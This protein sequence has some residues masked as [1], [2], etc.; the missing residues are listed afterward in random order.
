MAFLQQFTAALR[1]SAAPHCCTPHGGGG[2]GGKRV[3]TAA[4]AAQ[5]PQIVGVFGVVNEVM[6]G[7]L[8]MMNNENP[9]VLIFGPFAVILLLCRPCRGW[10]LP[11]FWV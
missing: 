1:L 8:V 5:I 3:V 2:G 10:G 11:F 6:N 7:I 4:A 9:C